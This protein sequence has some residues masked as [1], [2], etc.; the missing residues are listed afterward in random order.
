[1]PVIVAIPFTTALA[2]FIFGAYVGT[3]AS[4]ETE[5]TVTYPDRTVT[6]SRR[7]AKKSGPRKAPPP[8]ERKP[9]KKAAD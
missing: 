5:E 3:L 8:S 1:M 7:S 4:S 9:R 6:R 2:S